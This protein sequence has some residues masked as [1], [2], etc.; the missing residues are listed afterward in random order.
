MAS[1]RSGT[2]T[3]TLTLHW[4]RPVSTRLLSMDTGIILV[5]KLDSM[6]LRVLWK[7]SSVV[8]WILHG[9]HSG[10]KDL[11]AW[12]YNAA[13]SSHGYHRTLC[14]ELL[15]YAGTFFFGSTLQWMVSSRYII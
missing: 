14:K 13:K 12:W 10:T 3:P 6:C 7:T 11:E 1:E 15:K 5:G 2:V 9:I 4:E 8:R